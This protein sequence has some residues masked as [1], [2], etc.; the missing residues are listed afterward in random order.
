M[1]IGLMGWVWHALWLQRAGDR[2]TRSSRL[3]N[4]QQ[5]MCNRGPSLVCMYSAPEGE[6]ATAHGCRM[7]FAR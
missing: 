5:A 3:H 2:V 7:P 6:Q 1:Y 4:S